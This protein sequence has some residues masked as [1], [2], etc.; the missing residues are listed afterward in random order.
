[1]WSKNQPHL[2]SLLL[3]VVPFLFV[4]TASAANPESDILDK[5]R[6]ITDGET[7][8]SPGGS[9][10]LG[11]F[12]P[13]VLGKRYLGI[14]F[15]MDEDAICWVAN[16]DHPLTDARGVLVIS[17]TRSLLLIDSSGQVVWSSNTTGT[18]ST[19]VQLLESGNLVSRDGNA[20]GA[21]TWQSFDHPSN[22]LLPGMKIG[23]NLWTGEEWYL[24]SWRSADD[25]ATG[26]FRY[27]TDTEGVPQNVMLDGG[28]RIYRT[29]PWNGLWFSGV[30]E[31]GTYSDMFIYRL[32]SSPSEITYGYVAKA[33]TPF[34]R[35]VLTDDGLFRRLVWDTS[36][37]AWKIF[38]QGPR[39]I[40]DQYGRCGAFGLCNA[41]APSTSFCSCVRG[42][43]PASPVQWKMRDT[44]NGCRRN[45][46]LD[47]GNGIST[48]DGF[49]VMQGVKLPDT[50]N[51]S[52]DA[53][54]T[55]EE[56]RTRC[57]ANC[58]CLAYA[59]LDLKGGGT[60]TGCIIW[61]EDLMDLRHV[62]GGQSLF[63]R[64][65]K[66]EL[67][68]AQ[69]PK[70]FPTGIVIG[71]TVPLV[72]IILA[73]VAFWF[74]PWRR[75]WNRERILDNPPRVVHN[76]PRVVDNVAPDS[77]PPN[78][79]LLTTSFPAVGLPA[80][81][82]A[83]GNFSEANIIGKGGFS[84]IYK[85]E[86][87][88]YGTVAVKRLKQDSLS[89]K[90]KGDY[91]RE[92]VLMSRFTH[93]NLVKLLCYCQENAECIL[94]YEFMRNRSLNLYIFGEDSS[95][96]SLLNWAQRVKIIRGIAVGLEWLH[97]EGVIHRDLKPGNIL[98]ND[99]L[100]PKIADFGTAKTLIED[101]TNQTL[102]QT[103]GYVAPEYAGEGTLT[104]K[105]DVYSFGVVLLEIVRGKRK[106]DEPAFLPQVWESWKQCEIGELLDPQV[107]EPEEAFSVLARCIHIGLHCVQ[108]LPEQRP[109]MPDVVAMLTNT[110]THLPMPSNPTANIG[111]GPR[112]QP[113]SD[114][115]P[116][117]SRTL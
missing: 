28:K 111:A 13:G 84:V 88:G 36:S 39:D 63:L 37:R 92:I 74:S 24:T 97:G 45:V 55:L 107:G 8:V 109:A 23:K 11:F 113:I 52:V 102:V 100:E 98:L 99:T 43:S 4:S 93:A 26:N 66:S 7:L 59:P 82:Q 76:A 90:I 40:C 104:D 112:A 87:D 117:P 53:S 69:P 32:T 21:I 47:C 3:I 95:L 29:G 18:A 103:A 61:R 27:I 12:P 80:V 17:D 2:H 58:S 25:P 94:V 14:W 65:A 19:T 64:S 79:A 78:L 6:N 15:S 60:G 35:L 108:H 42:F 106:K 67:G 44:S 51:A 85:G 86:L 71:V 41:S 38:F 70:S 96:R 57:L 81:V 54:I 68:E 72:T 115:T 101:P 77:H 105:C 34:S 49:V 62:D 114:G 10:T 83:T 116:G 31:M 20:S 9:F 22:T 16:R 33:G 75:R 91:A 110:G 73:L 5:G 30:T 50:H 48:T 89:E 46:T 1:M 56:C